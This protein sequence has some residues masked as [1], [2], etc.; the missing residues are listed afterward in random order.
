M[1][2]WLGLGALVVLALAATFAAQ[3]PG[4]DSPLATVENRG[5]RG[6][7]V[8]ATWLSESGREVRVTD[9]ELP[10]GVQTVVLAAPSADE[11]SPEQLEPLRRFVEAGGTLVYLVPRQAPQAA[12]NRW[13]GVSTGELA[14]LNDA[15][16]V[17]DVGGSTVTV[18]GV[19]GVHTLRVSADRAL[20]VEGGE[21]A[22]E[23]GVL[24]TRQL[25]EGRV[26]LSAGADLAENARLELADNARFWSRLP[27]PLAF[28]ERHQRVSRALP[29]N[30]AA[31]G[32]QLLVLAGLFIWARGRRLGPPRDE[33][34]NTS[35]STMSYVHAL[36]NLLRKS[37]VE[38]EL[39]AALK[40][41][42]REAGGADDGDDLLTLSRRA[43]ETARARV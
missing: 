8:L 1:K 31:T 25:G 41:E 28:D 13:L 3:R 37:H 5:P 6:V 15:P 36:A 12:L 35:V 4:S 40:R 17:A 32:L 16:G 20:H 27:S 38:P 22:A 18:T 9:G 39:V 30:F 23:Y 42:L 21:E 29:I 2:R 11:Y 24:W 7:A 10:E 19:P 26:W 34:T 14:P 33:L 43:A